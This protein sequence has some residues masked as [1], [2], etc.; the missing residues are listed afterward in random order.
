MT[1]TQWLAVSAAVTAVMWMP[2]V[3]NRI[4]VLGLGRALGNPMPGDEE[5]LAP[6][7]QR[8][9]RAYLNAA[10]NL[11]V[12]A[13]LVLSAPNAE[14]MGLAVKIYFISRVVHFVTYVAGVPVLRTLAF[15]GG[16]AAQLL[17]A[18]GVL[19]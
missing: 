5:R 1:N 17:A 8:S 13:P 14:A 4:A 2:H 10:V 18:S 12:F 19:L 7:A 15:A 16:F 9:A 6:W 3:L 11:A